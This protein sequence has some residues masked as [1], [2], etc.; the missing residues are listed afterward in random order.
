MAW[1]A[2]G[3]GRAPVEIMGLLLVR[4]G[5]GG[6]GGGGGATPREGKGP[7]G[8]GRPG[9]GLWQ[10]LSVTPAR[11]NCAGMHIMIT[12]CQ[13]ECRAREKAKAA[14]SFFLCVKN[15]RVG[16]WFL[17]AT[18]G[19]GKILGENSEN[20][21]PRIFVLFIIA[22]LT[23]IMITVSLFIVNP[24]S[25]DG[26][27]YGQWG[28]FFGGLLNPILTFLTF[29][30]LLI[31]IIMQ[32]KELRETREELKRS[33]SALEIQNANNEKHKFE[34][35]FFHMLSF[36]EKIVSDIRITSPTRYI[37]EGQF[38][39]RECF[40]YMVKYLNYEIDEGLRRKNIS[41]EAEKSISDAIRLDIIEQAYAR[42]WKEHNSKLG[43]YFR[44]L[45][46]MLRFIDNNPH[47]ERIHIRL[48]RA[49]LSDAE[50][51]MIFYNAITGPGQNFRN[52]IEKHA[53]LDNLSRD[54][55]FYE[56]HGLLIAEVTFGPTTVQPNP[57]E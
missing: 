47:M 46:N 43:H 55:L 33:A 26:N 41:R 27:N 17:K 14:R 45:Y 13:K 34:E 36:H 51:I 16:N 11:Q 19:F 22:A 32:Q 49:Q 42:F 23:A 52:L 2:R 53:L 40:E 20:V 6:A 48:I 12:Q 50:M 7:G 44:F 15:S 10:A 39:G 21:L 3:Q 35:V 54:L 18:I 28:D 37:A 24:G 30:G 5:N 8:W 1:G 4:L 56:S 9:G 57:S 25:G 38:A 29:M 31:T